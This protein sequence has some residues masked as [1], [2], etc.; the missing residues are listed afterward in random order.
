MIFAIPSDLKTEESTKGD[1]FGFWD[2]CAPFLGNPHGNSPA[3]RRGKRMAP[4]T[5]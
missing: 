2:D 5:R 4:S 1:M 3:C